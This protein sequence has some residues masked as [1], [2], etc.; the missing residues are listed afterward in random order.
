MQATSKKFNPLFWQLTLL[1]WLI[2]FVC[3]LFLGDKKMFFFFN[4]KHTFLLDCFNAFLSF[5][6]RGE[7]IGVLLICFFFLKKCR[8]IVYTKWM[9]VYVA[10][11]TG[12]AY[13]LKH[14]FRFDRPL[15]VFRGQVN[16]VDWLT[17]QEIYSF[18]SGH[19]LAIFSF[20]GFC[21]LY[22]QLHQSKI[23]IA[24]FAL[25][26]GCGL[27]RIYLGQHFMRDI[28]FG[29]TLGLVIG[30]AIGYFAQKEFHRKSLSN[31]AL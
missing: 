27:S 22:F 29:C 3:W 20:F 5:I 2:G 1:V 26:V 25:A 15:L 23:Q 14:H 4:A 7:V 12:C 28:L 11:S 24:L 16:I 19:T 10:A 9:L 18:P 6:G 17:Q 31:L 30:S 13:Y 8:N 21:I